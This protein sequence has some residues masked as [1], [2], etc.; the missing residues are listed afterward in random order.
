VCRLCKEGPNEE[1]FG[2][3]FTAKEDGF[4]VHQYCLLF[5]SGL[6]QRGED[7]EGFD[8]FL[9]TDIKKEISRSRRLVSTL[10]KKIVKTKMWC[11]I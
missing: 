9:M 5:A 1:V 6:A 4:S 3:F 2:K 7:D 10:I 8:G 11:L